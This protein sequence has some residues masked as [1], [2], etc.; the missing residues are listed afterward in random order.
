VKTFT[1]IL[2]AVA[3]TLAASALFV[4]PGAG[5]DGAAKHYVCAPCGLP[6]DKEVF[7]QPGTCPKCGMALV[8]QGSLPPPPPQ[9]KV[10]ILIFDG[11][12]IIDYT[13]PW[14]MFG[15]ANYQ[16]YTVALS[17]QPVQTAMGMVVVPQY[18]FADAPQADVLLVP[19][20]GVRATC[21]SAP[22]LEWLKKTSPQTKQ[23]LSVCNGSFILA[24]AG[25]LDGLHATTTAGNIDRMRAKYPKV[26]VVENQRVVDN[27]K[28]STAAGL[29]SG[30]DGALH[31]ISKLDGQGMA[32]QVALGEEYDWRPDGGFVRA[33]LADRQIPDV[34]MDSMGDFHV[35]STQGTTDHWAIV[36]R[37]KS[38]L[39]T[40]ELNERIGKEFVTKGKWESV[41]S[42][43]QSSGAMKSAW[44]FSGRDGKPWNGEVTVEPVQGAD[45]EYD[46]ML[47]VARSG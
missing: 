32:E 15:A 6:C 11:V 19:G 30:I 16:V 29:S 41:P 4:A 3:L 13:A 1:R 40:P 12:E 17:K 33:A 27:G 38:K 26:T 34:D 7:D 21:E 18:T 9:K 10:A 43:G 45:H 36:V 8:E 22:T 31:V 35:V 39:T 20:G 14:E 5:A 28:I 44:K 24:S 46:V 23:T 47:R 37:G 2:A 25:L 42:N